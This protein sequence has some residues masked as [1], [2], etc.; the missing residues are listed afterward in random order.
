MKMPFK[1]VWKHSSKKWKHCSMQ[2]TK[3]T[4]TTIEHKYLT[5]RLT[6]QLLSGCRHWQW[7]VSGIQ[8]HIVPFFTDY[9]KP[10]QHTICRLHN[11]TTFSMLYI[12]DALAYIGWQWHN[13]LISYL[14]QLF[15]PPCCR[16][17]SAKC[18]L[19]G[20]HFLSKIAITRTFS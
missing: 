7:R 12:A 9:S 18:F 10:M 20:H 5:T 13:F 8:H 6:T 19:F 11:L 1:S 16:S 15:F 4:Q 2:S 17:S 14:C 3:N